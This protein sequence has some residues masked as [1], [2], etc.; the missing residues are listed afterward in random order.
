MRGKLET[1][2]LPH[3]H[4]EDAATEIAIIPLSSRLSLSC[5]SR[6]AKSMSRKS[7][8]EK[9]SLTPLGGRLIRKQFLDHLERTRSDEENSDWHR[10]SP[11]SQT[12]FSYGWT[13][14]FHDWHAHERRWVAIFTN[15]NDCYG[16]H[17]GLMNIYFVA[18]LQTKLFVYD[19]LHAEQPGMI[20]LQTGWPL[21]A[22][23]S[24][25]SCTR[26]GQARSILVISNINRVIK[27]PLNKGP[28]QRVLPA[29]SFCQFLAPLTDCWG[30]E[31]YAN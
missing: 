14:P 12:N 23:G 2:S 13:R 9:R 27:M 18:S 17:Y 6:T 28:W 16:F 22:C 8:S 26:W 5:T 1:S 29:C 3:H 24:H 30:W 4:R 10:A 19:Q 11:S 15:L 31:I 21:I 25:D 7:L 20:C